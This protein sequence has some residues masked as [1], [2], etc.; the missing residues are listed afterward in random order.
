MDDRP[1]PAHDDS[2][3]TPTSPTTSRTDSPWFWP[4]LGVGTAAVALLAA[5][6]ILRFSPAPGWV[7]FGVVGALLVGLAVAGYLATRRGQA[8]AFVAIALLLPYMMIGVVSYAGTQRVA[9]EVSSFLEDEDISDED[10]DFDD[11]PDVDL[12]ALQ[13]ACVGGDAAACDE[14]YYE[15]PVDSE[16]ERIA[17]DNDGDG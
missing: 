6:L 13:E 16:Y 5:Y 12:D 15:A 10:F 9:D 1:T 4:G 17:E 14:L 7:A 11:S 2:P 3:T 8:A